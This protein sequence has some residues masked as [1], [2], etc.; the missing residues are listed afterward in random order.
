VLTFIE[1]KD[2]PPLTDDD[3]LKLKSEALASDR[4]VEH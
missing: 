3:P 4:D 2:L 1:E